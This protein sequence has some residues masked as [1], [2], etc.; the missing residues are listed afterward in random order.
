MT[1]F[2]RPRPGRLVPLLCALGVAACDIPSSPPIFEQT[3][4]VPADSTTIGVSS[5][6]PTNVGLNGGGT[7]FTVTTPAANIPRTL[8]AICTDPACQ[9]PGPVTVPSTPAF[10]SGAG[11]LSNTINFPAGVN[12]LTVS[13]GTLQIQVTNNI[14]FDPIRPNGVAGPFGSITVGITSGAVTSNTVVNGSA[15]QGMPNGATT[16]LDIPVPTGNYASSVTVAVTLSAPAGPSATIA[17][18]NTFNIAASLVG[19]TVSNATVVVNSKPITTTPASFDLAGVDVGDV[20]QG[21]G[22]VLEVVNPFNATASLSLV[23]AAPPQGGGP[24]V[25]ISKSLNLA[26]STTSNLSLTLLKSELASLLGKSNVTISVTGNATGAGAGNTVS[27]SPTA[28]IKVRTK[29][30]ITIQVGG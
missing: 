19:F 21:G 27:V 13:G 6:L 23:L 4:I 26:A 30:S 12:A 24:A 7:A 15:T 16:T 1:F 18:G 20:V 29:L 25:S 9:N 10:S 5:L 2:L 8:G 22:L 17:S 3:W 14:G 28:E 11:A